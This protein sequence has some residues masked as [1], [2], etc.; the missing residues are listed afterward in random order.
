MTSPAEPEQCAEAEQPAEPAADASGPDGHVPERFGSAPRS[1]ADELR[2]W[3]DGDLVTLLQ[4]RPDLAV[5]LVGDLTSL[6]ARAASRA[7][8]QRALDGLDT[9]GLQVLE[10]VAALPEPVSPTEI[11]RRWGSP[12]GPVLARLRALALVWGPAR[13]VWLVR[14]ARDLIGPNPAGLGPPLADALGRR[15]PQR[16]DQLLEDL[17]LPPAADP[18][19]ALRRLAEHLGRPEIIEQLLADAPDGVLAVLDR[20]TWGPPVGQV[21][22]AERPARVATARRPVDWL[23]A[24][25]LLAV[26]DAAHVVLPREVGLALRGG[27]VHR[28]PQPRPPALRS[29]RLDAATVTSAASAAAVEAV[30]LVDALGDLW[31]AGPPP[32]LRSGGLG[33]R[34]LRRVASALD[35][36]ETRAALVVELSYAAG[37]VADDGEA[38]PRWGPTPALDAWRVGDTGERWAELAAAWLASSR[39]PRLVGTRD[40]RDAT[41]A[42]LSPAIDR[43]AAPAVRAWI[44]RALAEVRPAGGQGNGT[45]AAGGL[46]AVDA[47]AM[48]PA[49]DWAVPRRAG[50]TRDAM[51]G[52]TLDEADWL[53]VT[54]RGALARHARPLLADPPDLAAAAGVLEEGLPEPVDRILLQA[55]LT[56]VAPGPLAP[57]LARELELIADVESRGGATVYR[58]SPSSIRRGLDAGRSADDLL[59]LLTGHAST[60]VPQ[61]LQYLITDIA[62]RHGRM[63]VSAATAYIRADD[64][65]ALAAL[66]ADRRAASLR[67][68]RLAPTVLAAQAPPQVVLEVLRELGLAPAAESPDG[69]LLLGL[70]RAYRTPA[71][72]RPRPLSP[73]PPPPP[74][75]ALSAAVQALRAADDAASARARAEALAGV[76]P[77]Q[78]PPLAAMDPLGVLAVLRDAAARRRPV[79]IGYA[80]ATGTPS[81]RLVQPL[82]VEAGRVDA[83]DRGTQEIRSFSVH[84]VTGVALAPA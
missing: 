39:C 80:D 45:P 8:V 71:R 53:G 83:F 63:R 75:H 1:L 2:T 82:H 29:Q 6:A 9:P 84:R 35:L 79:W 40:S 48:R 7:S 33:V 23:L 61:P 76:D 44:L 16:L 56:A 28:S 77:D 25:G 54:G 66:L 3:P 50:P 26:A 69:E 38:E 60:A 4:A 64:E 78:A 52:W 47:E 68:R 55:D 67:L 20:L 30:R 74:V 32:V 51:V 12:A 36:D 37:L 27:R 65:A 19:S 57:D 81:R 11:S 22:D 46:A 58:F 70:P 17:G 24:R 15:S 18:P 41:R 13:S 14:T 10:A 34:E 49:L 42:A 21:M 43:A 62:R 73:L 5:P 59:T 31:G 72:A